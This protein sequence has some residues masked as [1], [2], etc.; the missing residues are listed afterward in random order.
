MAD[1]VHLHTDMPT[2]PRRERAERTTRT[3]E[4]GQHPAEWS[5]VTAAQIA[6][7][8]NEIHADLAALRGE[9]LAPDAW[10]SERVRVRAAWNYL[11]PR[12]TDL[13]VLPDIRDRITEMRDLHGQIRSRLGL[14]RPRQI[15]PTPC[16]ACDLRTLFRTIAPGNDVIQCGNCGN[17]IPEE[18][19]PF[20]TRVILDTILYRNGE[21]A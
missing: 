21:T 12:I 4:Y 1:W 3:R 6:R 20:Y 10:V 13:T 16:P 15:L 2:P 9:S 11:E 8:L 17:V 18:H 5:S 19:Y 14:T 7:V